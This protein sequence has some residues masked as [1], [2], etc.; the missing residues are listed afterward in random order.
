VFATRSPHRP[1]PIGLSLLRLLEVR[2][3]TLRVADVDLLDRTPILDI[4]PYLPYAEAFPDAAAGWLEETIDRERAAGY[5]RVEWS[6]FAHEQF[7]SLQSEHGIELRR[8]VAQ[9]ILND[10]HP[11]P[12]RR[13]SP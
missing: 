11:H 10:P 3:L 6:P 2:G 5:L 7:A 9:V 13:I 1:N 4:R 8:H 12:Y